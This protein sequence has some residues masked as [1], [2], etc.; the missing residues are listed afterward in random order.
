MAYF[1]AKT[2]AG[3]MG[4]ANTA[5]QKV[6]TDAKGKSIAANTASGKANDASV[7]AAKA[8]SKAN[9]VLKAAVALQTK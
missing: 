4:S 1:N 5:A 8:A 6:Y 2:K 3:S 9:G 7:A